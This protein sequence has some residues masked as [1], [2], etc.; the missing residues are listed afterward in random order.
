MAEPTG[1]AVPLSFDRPGRI[2]YPCDTLTL[3]VVMWLHRPSE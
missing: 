3:E 2:G 1:M